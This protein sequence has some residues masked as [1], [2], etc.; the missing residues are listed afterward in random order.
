MLYNIQLPRNK[1]IALEPRCCS[2]C[3]I[4]LHHH[5]TVRAYLLKLFLIIPR[6]ITICL[7]TSVGKPQ[8]RTIEK[9]HKLTLLSCIILHYKYA[10]LRYSK[11][12]QYAHVFQ[13]KPNKV[14]LINGKVG[15]WNRYRRFVMFSVSCLRKLLTARI[16]P[17]AN[18]IRILMSKFPSE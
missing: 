10:F 16:I 18:K 3:T 1:D 14:S 9:V 13:M 5:T 7:F 17:R 12:L 4:I 2:K 11:S 15:T 6:I 8:T